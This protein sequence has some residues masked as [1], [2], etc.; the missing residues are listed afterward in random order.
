V[1]RKTDRRQQEITARKRS[2]GFDRGK[3]GWNADQD[4]RLY[5]KSLWNSG[6]GVAGRVGHTIFCFSGCPGLGVGLPAAGG[7]G[8]LSCILP[9]DDGP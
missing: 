6:D 2:V 8:V 9:E 7:Q 5:K 4:Q 3:D 1:A